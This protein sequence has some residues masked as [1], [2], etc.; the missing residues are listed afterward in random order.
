MIKCFWIRLN[1]EFYFTAYTCM[2][3]FKIGYVNNGI[4][5]YRHTCQVYNCFVAIGNAFNVMG[6]IVQQL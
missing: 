4:S 6:K 1:A 2:Y 3:H 5:F